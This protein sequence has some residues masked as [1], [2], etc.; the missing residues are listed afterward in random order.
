MMADDEKDLKNA[1]PSIEQ[2]ADFIANMVSW[3]EST[4]ATDPA[5]LDIIRKH[6]LKEKPSDDAVNQAT[7]AI[8]QLA[9]DRAMED[10]DV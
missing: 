2:P 5:L 3:L 1:L 4:R 6:I 8:W 9:A 7:A 10:K